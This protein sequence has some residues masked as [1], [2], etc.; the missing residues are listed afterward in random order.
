MP[1]QIS[2]K[3]RELAKR[4][5]ADLQAQFT[6]VDAIAQTNAEKVLDAFQTYRVAESDFA[7]TTGYGYDDIG[8]DKLEKIY[9]HIFH[10][11]DALVRLQFVNGTHAITCA[12]FGA[13]KPGE[14]LLYA[15]GAPYD[16]IQSA[17]GITGS[18]PGS[19]KY[20]GIGYRQAELTPQGNP[21]LVAIAEA[22]RDPTVKA[23]VIQRS[24]GYAT[25]PTL[26]VSEIGD[27]C[28][29]IHAVRNLSLI[30]I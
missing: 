30:H 8:R 26:S 5:E 12:L 6:N 15:V 18:A 22:L 7:G 23:A 13:L 3:T 14:A 9:A 21:D 25:R 20:Y 27:I 2:K 11:E 17:I 1:L 4:A 24:R 10:T 29:A 28:R 16:T 19:L